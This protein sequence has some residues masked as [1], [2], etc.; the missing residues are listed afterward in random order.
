M[1]LVTGGCG[2]IGSH[3]CLELLQAGYQVVVLDNL[4]NASQESLSRIEALTGKKIP[5]VRGDV[6][7]IG[8]LNQI[9]EKFSITSV[10]HFAGLKAVGES[11]K[12]PLRYYENNVGGSLCLL[13]TRKT[14]HFFSNGNISRTTNIAP[15]SRIFYTTKFPMQD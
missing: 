7:D 1:I 8:C 12:L 14:H 15:F 6:R 4:S 2:Y 10:M 13:N 5:F 3:T 11:V 9:F